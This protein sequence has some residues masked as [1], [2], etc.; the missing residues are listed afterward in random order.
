[1]HKITR[2]AEIDHM[3]DKVSPVQSVVC[4][5]MILFTFL[6]VTEEHASEIAL[7]T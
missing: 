4:I 7:L 1:M 5:C 6:S 3:H 2:S